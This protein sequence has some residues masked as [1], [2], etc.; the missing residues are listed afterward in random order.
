MRYFLELAYDGT[1][2]HGWQIQPNARTVQEVLD[3]C[4]STILRQPIETVGSGRTDT[5]VHAARQFAHFDLAHALPDNDG[6]CYRLNR[7]LPPDISAIKLYPVGQAA[8]ARF[9]AV[10]RTYEYRI[11][12]VKNP[13]L[14]RYA[15][16]LNRPVDINLLNEAAALLLTV[17]DFTTFSKVKGDTLHYR[18]QMQAAYWEQT[19]HGLCFIIRANR[20]L[21]GMV[22]LVVGTLL[23]V[24]AGKISPAAFKNLLVAQDRRQAS[25]AA[26]AAGLFLTQVTYPD[27]Y[28]AEQKEKFILD[29]TS[30]LL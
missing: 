16:Y 2:Y 13:F 7:L 15:H 19:E 17:E 11:T 30:A 26:P 27:N 8:H 12:Q 24:G 20:F 22:R 28:F 9:D 5:G 25:G 14:Q 10:A 29:K 3:K 4:L 21:R 1:D 23:D 18:C 6:L